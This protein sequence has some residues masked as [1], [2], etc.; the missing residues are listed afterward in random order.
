M[1]TNKPTQKLTSPIKIA[2]TGHR[3]PTKIT[4]YANHRDLGFE[5]M[6]RWKNKGRGIA[7]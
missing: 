4:K 5:D 7:G 1:P 6:G 3:Q 2:A